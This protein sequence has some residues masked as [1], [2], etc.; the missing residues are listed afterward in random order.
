MVTKFYQHILALAFA[1]DEV[2]KDSQILPNVSLGFHICDM[3]YDARMTYRTTLDLLFRSRRFVPNYECHTKKNLIALV[4]GLSSDISFHMKDISSLYKIPQVTTLE[5][6]TGSIHDSFFYGHLVFK[7]NTSNLT[8][9][10][11]HA[12]VSTHCISMAE[13]VQETSSK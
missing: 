4:G 10:S 5:W 7:S 11:S 1:V 3:Y 13:A 12:A 2:N 8:W 6:R 9:L